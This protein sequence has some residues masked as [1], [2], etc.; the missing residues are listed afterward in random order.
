MYQEGLVILLQFKNT[1]YKEGLVLVILLH[2]KKT[3]DKEGLAIFLDHPSKR[4]QF[5]LWK[6][7]NRDD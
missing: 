3:I 4:S 6:L 1:I 2:F 7:N 5:L